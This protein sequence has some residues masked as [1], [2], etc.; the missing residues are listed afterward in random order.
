MTVQIQ[1]VT[2]RNGRSPGAGGAI[3]N[4][5]DLTLLRTVL[6]GNSSVAGAAGAGL[7]GAI[8]SDGHDASLT[9]TRQHDRQQHRPERRRRHRRRR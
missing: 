8:V 6:T 2:L 7:G 4:N 5:G 3:R 1:D 9:I